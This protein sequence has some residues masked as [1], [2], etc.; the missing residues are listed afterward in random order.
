MSKYRSS[1][2]TSMIFSY[3]VM[4]VILISLA[5]GYLYT[6]ASGLMKEEMARDSQQRLESARDYI[7]ETLLLKL[8]NFAQNISLSAGFAKNDANLNYLLD[9]TWQGNSSRIAL[10]SKALEM[11]ALTNDG[12][13]N[14][15]IYFKSGN[16]V[17][18][19]T[20][21]FMAPGNSKDSAFMEKLS[22]DLHG[23]W[24]ARELP[25]GQQALTFVL[26]L[27]YNQPSLEPKG[28][29]F[30]DATVD[31]LE[32]AIAQI[33][34]SPHEKLYVF[35]EGQRL[36]M[37]TG[38]NS[39][40]YAEVVR[41]AIS[42]PQPLIEVPLRDEGDAIL[43]H[44]ISSQPGL[45]WSF[46]IIRPVQSFSLSFAGFKNSIFMICGI[47][48]LVGILM[49]YLFSK[50][51]YMPMQGLLQRIGTSYGH[52]AQTT[53]N[54]YA[55]IG[56]ALNQM[57]QKI[58]R[59]ETSAKQNEMKNLVLG[60]NLNLEFTGD[61]PEKMALLTAYIR[62]TKGD[63]TQL[64]TLYEAMYAVRE[65]EVVCLNA[66]EAAIIYFVDPAEIRPE[67]QIKTHLA[68]FRRHAA[69]QLS[70]GA[71][72]GPRV[73]SSDE[74]PISYQF[75]KSTFRYSFIYG[76]EAIMS[77]AE[78]ASY[79][80]APH[81]MPY[82]Q[83]VNALK[84]GDMEQAGRFLDDFS[85]TLSRGG[86]QLE[87]VEL[88]LLQLV[89]ALYQAVIDLQLLKVVQPS[90][91]FDEL[92]KDSL[93]DTIAA[94]RKHSQQ[95]VHHVKES[96]GHAHT[97]IILQLK[98]YIDEHL[99]EDLSLNV[100][101]EKA[102]LAPAYIST[103]FGEVMRE[104]FTEYVTRSRLD[105]AAKLLLDEPRMSVADV[106][107]QVGYRNSQYFHNKF[108]VRFGI[109]PVQYRRALKAQQQVPEHT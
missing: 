54:E 28:Y 86:H 27:P 34:T 41:E 80:A 104:T 67:E 76:P 65:Y 88:S 19:K 22:P 26:K 3:T 102:A 39:M 75:A 20:S 6:R 18:D 51:L 46:A 31:Y 91:L 64:R 47:V 70:F 43:S 52:P 2:F 96:G 62:I 68:D 84:A 93:D 23:H 29:L 56:N 71:A 108:K 63:A 97:D 83:F 1:V 73:S 4:A 82:E 106:A 60:A 66:E 58:S 74:I 38:A 11:Y 13:F 12:V 50:K 81:L 14:S 105:K 35:D 59:L 40:D 87:A 33:V 85:A 30:L 57:D 98:A 100:L 16:Y 36:I 94:I 79:D 37:A 32:N 99:H 89:S 15:T 101:S 21:F 55:Y 53:G 7:E 24:I 48:L 109:T 9:N 77:Y 25:D 5:G 103:L 69:E 10:F 92:K 45:G 107:S 78:V 17:I 8:E 72:L 49:S 61:F 44:M 95:I 42:D 90:S